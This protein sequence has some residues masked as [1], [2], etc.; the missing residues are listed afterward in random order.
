VLRGAILVSLVV[1]A[2]QVVITVIAASFYNIFAEL[3]GGLEIT[4]REE[5]VS[6]R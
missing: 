6:P 4:V 3:F 1:V 2:M 5:E